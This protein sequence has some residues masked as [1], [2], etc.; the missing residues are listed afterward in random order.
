MVSMPFGKVVLHADTE[1]WIE[2]AE[3]AMKHVEYT[4]CVRSS[5]LLTAEYTTMDTDDIDPGS[6]AQ[7]CT[8]RSKGRDFEYF[9]IGQQAVSYG[10]VSLWLQMP[11]SF[12][13]CC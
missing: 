11:A 2:D 12:Q 10:T 8:A 6:C 13:T 1:S 3:T 9:L 7:L 5:A 4:G